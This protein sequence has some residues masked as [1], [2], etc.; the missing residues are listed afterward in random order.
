MQTKHTIMEVKKEKIC[1]ILV[2]SQVNEENS[3]I[4]KDYLVSKTKFRN[5][6]LQLN[7]ALA[8]EG[9]IFIFC[10]KGKIII[11]K[12]SSENIITENTIFTILPY[13]VIEISYA[14]ADLDIE[15]QFFSMDYIL[16]FFFSSGQSSPFSIHVSPFIKV[17][18]EELDD[19]LDYHYFILSK[20]VTT[21]PYREKI[22][23]RLLHTLIIAV[24]GL[25][26]IHFMIEK[27]HSVHVKKVVDRF[28]SLLF[29]YSKE[30]K[31]VAFFADKLCLSPK[32]VSTLILKH[33]GRPI[34]FWVNMFLTLHAKHLLKS[35]DLTILQIS[36]ELG[37]SNPS[38]FGKYFKRETG[39]SPGKYRGV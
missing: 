21:H 16:D 28:F 7:Q 18:K 30:K 27:T 2:E 24:G 34:L 38:F 33:T 19:I 3:L 39:I 26:G 10:I 9:V 12:N 31:N 32:Y 37:F 1:R 23:K 5:S 20:S 13:H 22:L 8:F 29:D 14:S 4:L 35:T 6:V 11:K 25:Y 36:E 17:E 15:Y